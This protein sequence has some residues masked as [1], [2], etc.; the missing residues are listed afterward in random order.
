LREPVLDGH[1]AAHVAD[2]PPAPGAKATPQ[3]VDRAGRDA[4]RQRL[5]PAEPACPGGGERAVETILDWFKRY[6]V[7]VEAQREIRDLLRS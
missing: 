2:R 7:S 6:D 5:A 3:E 4:E 1:L